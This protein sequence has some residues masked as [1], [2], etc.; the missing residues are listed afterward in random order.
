MTSWKDSGP[1]AAPSIPPLRG[2]SERSEG[3]GS[4]FSG[5]MHVLDVD[6]HD[7]E[8]D[9]FRPSATPPSTFP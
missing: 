4:Y 9:P 2:G 3:V 7:N 6:E 8:D 1:G 5:G